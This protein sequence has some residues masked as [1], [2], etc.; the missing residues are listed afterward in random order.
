MGG[1]APWHLLC[2]FN[3]DGC[4]LWDVFDEGDGEV[5][6]P[7]LQLLTL[8]LRPCVSP[9]GGYCLLSQCC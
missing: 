8:A 3:A 2:V 9:P 6:S 7:D 4:W 1:Q 5:C